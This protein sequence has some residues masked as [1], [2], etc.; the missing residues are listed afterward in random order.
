VVIPALGGFITRKKSA[1]IHAN[2]NLFIPP[3][4]H[5]IFNARLT[6]NDGLL[7]HTIALDKNISYES[8][9]D[10]I[11]DAVE[12][13]LIQLYKG[14]DVTLTDI[15]VLSYQN[16]LLKFNPNQGVNIQDENYGLNSFMMPLLQNEKFRPVKVKKT[17]QKPI[18]K[19]YQ[20]A[21]IFIFLI[22]ALGTF[23]FYTNPVQDYLKSSVYPKIISRVAN[24]SSVT[25]KTDSDHIVSDSSP[26]IIELEES[27]DDVAE[28][29]VSG[30]EILEEESVVDNI[31][32]TVVFDEI[33]KLEIAEEAAVD[34]AR[35]NLPQ[36][37]KFYIIMGSFRTSELAE[38]FCKKLNMMGY[39]AAEILDIPNSKYRR[40]S[41]QN[42]TSYKEATRCLREVQ[43]QMQ[44][45]AWILTGKS[46]M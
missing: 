31:S 14:D 15:G 29:I 41:L 40:V 8:A 24:I 39:R 23:A 3:S 32:E 16:G 45:D 9:L 42:Y 28:E 26:V 12:Q 27:I 44:S 25:E 2:Q 43:D 38:E 35:S 1:M 7:A 34:N 36:V 22:L 6:H 13:I 5:L 11:D 4:K 20:T 19:S 46:E 10:I 21:A 33:A 30:G 37:G 17:P 18:L